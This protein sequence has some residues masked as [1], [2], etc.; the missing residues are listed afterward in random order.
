M[1]CSYCYLF[2][3]VQN[4][5]WLFNGVVYQFSHIPLGWQ[6]FYYITPYN[7]GVYGL[8]TSQMGQSNRIINVVWRTVDFEL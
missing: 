2:E 1:F 7:H 5:F 6:W 3:N 4:L 8:A